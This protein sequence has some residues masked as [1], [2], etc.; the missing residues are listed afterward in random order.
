MIALAAPAPAPATFPG[1]NGAFSHGIDG[2]FGVA[3]VT[4][5]G[6]GQQTLI[7]LGEAPAYSPDGRWIAYAVP[8]A[9]TGVVACASPAPRARTGAC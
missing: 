5:D 6:T 9:A 7:A 2:V 4:R 1:A 3:P 8:P